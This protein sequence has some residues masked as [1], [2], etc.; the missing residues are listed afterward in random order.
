MFPCVTQA[1]RC[2]SSG[3]MCFENA[4]QNTNSRC[5]V[6]CQKSPCTIWVFD[7]DLLCWGNQIIHYKDNMTNIRMPGRKSTGETQE[8][9]LECSGFR[10]TVFRHFQRTFFILGLRLYSERLTLFR[11]LTSR[12]FYAIWPKIYGEIVIWLLKIFYM[13]FVFNRWWFAKWV[14]QLYIHFTTEE[15]SCILDIKKLLYQ[16]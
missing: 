9:W 8:T 13:D 11:G 14:V 16:Q 7:F 3:E 1:N 4:T 5:F 15:S 10:A 2:S 6:H 12:K